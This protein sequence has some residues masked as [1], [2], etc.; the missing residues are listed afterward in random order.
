MKYQMREQMFAI[1]DDYWVENA[2]GDR[3]FATADPI[4]NSKDRRYFPETKHIIQ[5]G[6]K[7]TWET[8]GGLSIFGLPLSEE[9][10]EQ[11]ADGKV[12]P[13]QYFERAVFD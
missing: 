2:A 7:E 8:K 12:H 1:G 6:F 11:L 5:Y 9:V 4:T 3:V 13:V 10:D